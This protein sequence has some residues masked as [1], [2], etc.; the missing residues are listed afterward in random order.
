MSKATRSLFLIIVLSLFVF[1]ANSQT[2]L[3]S[4]YSGIGPGYISEV[5][6][7]KNWSLG[8][9]S[10]GMRDPFTINVKNPA[11]YTAIDTTSFL[12]EAGFAGHYMNL[13]GDDLSQQHTTGSLSHLLFGF[14]VADWW[15]SS[16]G[17]LPFSTV[18]YS[19]INS[20][21]MDGIGQVQHLYEGDGGVSRFFWGNAFR[22]VKNISIGINTSYLFGTIDRTQNISFPDS[23]NMLGTLV[24]NSITIGDLYFDLGIQYQTQLNEKTRLVLGATYMPKLNLSAKRN[25][26]A[27]SYLGE[28]NQIQ[29]LRDTIASSI[30]EAG[31]IVMP[32]GYGFGFSVEREGK[33]LVGAD[34][35]MQNWEEYESFNVK[36][37]L[38]NSYT[39][40]VGGQYTPDMFNSYSYFKRIDYRLGAK[41]TKSNLNIK[42][43]DIDEIGMT[44]GFGFPVK[45]TALHRSIAKIN[46]GF[47]VG[48]RGTLD[49]NLIQEN[50]VKMFFGVTIYQ[51][52]FMKR[53]YD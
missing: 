38:R 18:G 41:Y 49:N 28:I 17:L 7:V 44:F 42:D 53:R 12:F 37:S 51:T 23:L 26:I 11:S 13:K 27:Q 50:Y 9:V 19:I 36:D 5:N 43:K 2:G 8:G 4:P 31:K 48:R 1:R 20:E 52:W 25:Y 14:P 46:L 10:I 3:N 21:P 16:I 34:F 32:T 6:S 29:I 45:R 40:A 30:D 39:M 47:E 15:R 33:W 24:N 35:K 22:P